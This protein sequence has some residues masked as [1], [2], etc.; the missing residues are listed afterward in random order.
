MSFL[1][2]ILGQ[3]GIFAVNVISSL[4]YFGVFVL[5]VLESMVFPMP[6]ELVMPF[7][8]FI[9]YQGKFNFWLVIFFSSLG[10]IVGSLLSYYAGKYLG[11][12][13]VIRYGKY[14]FL[15]VDDLKKTEHWFSKK[16]ESTI[17]V[18]RLIPVVR[19]LISIPAGIAKMNLT[20]F[21]VYTLIGAAIWNSIL[22]YLGYILGKNWML[23]RQYS[24][25]FSVAAAFIILLGTVYFIY[26][27]FKKP[28]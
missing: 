25:P 10:S 22:A 23:V 2:Q 20:K 12:P 11:N 27:H 14:F 7:A 8:G 3:I 13:F 4:G 16:G 9:A 21:C 17:F 26:K 5:M 6:S 18:A 19:H 28:K 1:E 24:E 15:N